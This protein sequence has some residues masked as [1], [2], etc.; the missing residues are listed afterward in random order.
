MPVEEFFRRQK[1]ANFEE[2]IKEFDEERSYSFAD[3]V[4]EEQHSV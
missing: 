2:F 1:I 4:Y 3:R